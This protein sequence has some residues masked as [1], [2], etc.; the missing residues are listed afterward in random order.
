MT[1]YLIPDGKTQPLPRCKE[2]LFAIPV[3]DGWSECH[4]NPPVRVEGDLFATEGN[5]AFPILRDS[6]FCGRFEKRGRRLA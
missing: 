1:P 6:E 2:C 5:S 4:F 3:G